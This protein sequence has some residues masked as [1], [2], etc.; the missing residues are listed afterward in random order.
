MRTAI[1]F[2]TIMAATTN[3][4]AKLTPAERKELTADLKQW[5]TL[6]GDSAQRN[7]FVPEGLSLDTP[8]DELLVR[9]KAAKQ[10]VPELAKE[11]PDASFTHLSPLALLTKDEFKHYVMKSFKRGKRALRADKVDWASVG[12]ASASGGV[13]WTKD[14]KCVNPVKNQGN[15]GSCWAF[16]ATGTVESAHCIATGTLLDL[17]DQQTTSCAKNGNLG[18]EGG[19]EDRAITWIHDNGG[20]CLSKDYPYTSGKSG[21]TGSCK[22][23]C[24]KQKLAIG[25]TVNIKGE[26][27]LETALKTQPVSVAVEAGNQVSITP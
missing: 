20:I 8:N 27:P 22:S 15:C 7:G 4:N 23:S 17:S 14:S 5:Q 26:G 10:R 6:F 13:D 24:T 21:Q 2:A 19:L 11:N 1:I 25:A 9:M 16:S 18:C 12:A 3:A